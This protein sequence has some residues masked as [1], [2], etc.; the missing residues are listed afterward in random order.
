MK[1][2]EDFE[3]V[4]ANEGGAFPRPEAGGYVVK[5]VHAEDVPDREY[6]KLEYDIAEGAFKGYYTDTMERAGFWG[7][8]LYRSYKK[9]T[10]DFFKGFVRAVE[11]SNPGYCWDWDERTLEGKLVG[12][13]LGEEEY[14]K[15]DGTIGTRLTVCQNMSCDSIRAGRFK[16]PAKKTIGRP[17]A[18]MQAGGFS[19]LG[20]PLAEDVELPF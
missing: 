18:A 10:E 8:T 6:L 3:S 1:R 7:A 4:K 5:I 2:I 14:Q 11:E 9:G 16:T 15:N 19:D 13:V 20:D 12:F 17:Q